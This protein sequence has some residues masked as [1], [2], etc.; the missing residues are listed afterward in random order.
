M[1]PY[2]GI[3]D[4]WF[5]GIDDQAPI[6]KKSK[7]F[8]KWF[9]ASLEFDQEISKRFKEVL[10]KAQTGA[11]DSWKEKPQG[12]LALVILFDQFTRNIYRGS[13]HVYD[14]DQAALEIVTEA[15]QLKM[16]RALGLIERVFLY[17][18]LMHS[19]EMKSQIL[20]VE[21]FSA[22]VEESKQLYPANTHYYIYHFN[23]AQKFF[24]ELKKHGH[25]PHRK[26]HSKT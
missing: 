26:K 8:N 3:L 1:C 13:H 14:H 16:D 18:P 21:C 19:E 24:N 25:F 22:L 5:E 7:P 20:S 15:I 9:H 6:D 17:M 4:F 23:Y 11:F 10:L 12:R 2:Q